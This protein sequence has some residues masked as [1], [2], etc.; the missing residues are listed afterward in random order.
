MSCGYIKSN[1]TRTFIKTNRKM[2]SEKY[3]ILLKSDLLLDIAEGEIF[4]DDV[5]PCNTL[6]EVT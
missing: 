5:S 6:H 2:K 4:Q 3:I 1:R